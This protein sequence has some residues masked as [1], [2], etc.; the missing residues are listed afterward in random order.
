MPPM[1]RR[2][3]KWGGA[4]LCLGLIALWVASAWLYVGYIGYSAGLA[5]F[6]G[7]VEVS[8]ET[9]SGGLPFN[10]AGRIGWHVVLSREVQFRLGFEYFAPLPP[11]AAQATRAVC[12]IPVWSLALLTLM[13]TSIAWWRDRAARKALR[14]RC[15]CGYARAGL[16]PGA[17]C[18]ECG[19]VSR[20]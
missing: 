8:Y 1:F 7:Q 20:G 19:S 17:P 6:A 2:T 4:A 16:P 15:E 12:Y 9:G 13:P 3:V 11:S 5:V 14:G 10:Y 18:P